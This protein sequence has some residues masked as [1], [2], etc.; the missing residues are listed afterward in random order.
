MESLISYA[1]CA[2]GPAESPILSGLDWELRSGE[3]WVVTGPNGGGKSAFAAAL[4]GELPVRALAGG[5]LRSAFS[6]NSVL[7]S[8][9]A[10]AAV[11]ER[12]RA[13]DDS[14]FVEG[15]IDPGTLVRRFIAGVLPPGAGASYPQGRGLESHPAVAV[16]GIAPILDRG[17][18]RLSTGEIRR[19]LLARALAAEPGL[20]VLDEP[21][22]G[23]DAASRVVLDGILDR[24]AEESARTAGT[25]NRDI[26]ARQA[27]PGIGTDA[28]DACVEEILWGEGGVGR[29]SPRLVL[30]ADRWERIPRAVNRVVELSGLSVSFSGDRGEWETLLASRS[31][32]A[33]SA[34]KAERPG[35]LAALA[36]AETEAGWL[37]AKGGREGVLV[38]MKNVTVA[39][40]ERKVLDS[41]SWTVRSGEHW[42]VRGPNGSGKTTLLEL[43]TGDNP[44]AFC[45]D[46]SLFGKRRGSGETIWDLKARM[47]IVSY[48]LHLEYRYLDDSSLEDVLV[49]GLHD[50]IGLYVE[51]GDAQISL[52]R[53][54]LALAGFA[55][56][57]RERFGHLSFGEQRAVLVARA[58][59]KNPLLLVLD[60]PCHGLDAAHRA[61]V[62]AL[63]SAIAEGGRST[64]I[65]VTHDPGEVLPC[66]KRIL[67]LRPGEEPSWV[68]LGPE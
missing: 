59:V 39:W 68:A 58:A 67:E 42:L 21:Y 38:E 53:H 5:A 13:N 43:I 23:L 25:A 57:E 47:G 3:A 14:D 45:N 4:A 20:L 15:G 62:L 41:L 9:E 35:L 22:E 60:E 64:L 33:E 18:K 6:G 65:H 31:A 8:F 52:A 55:G 19:T 1:N 49:S 56:R 11:I 10:A 37:G 34:A 44:Q 30:V 16:C 50:S 46:V 12:E 27:G 36:A 2:V 29:P 32:E 54:W 17:L 40:S 28:V 26:P 7:V 24:L 63:L 66:E 48:R 51:A 61:R